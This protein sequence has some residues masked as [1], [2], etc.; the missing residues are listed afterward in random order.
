MTP[1]PPGNLSHL[2]RL[3][4]AAAARQGVAVGRYQRWINVQIVSAVLDRAR[5]E[6]RLTVCP[7]GRS[8]DGAPA[9]SHRS[10]LEGL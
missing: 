8:S 3:A 9:R 10:R 5:Q 7:E 2:Q 4:N 1:K 6:R